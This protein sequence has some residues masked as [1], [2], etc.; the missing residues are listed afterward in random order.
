MPPSP[1]A[2][3]YTVDE[4]MSV[5][6]SRQLED[7]EMVAQGLATPL[8]VAGFLLAK[9][10]HAPNLRFASAIG[11]ALVDDWAPLELARIERK[12]GFAL[13]IAPNMGE[14]P[15]P[16]VEEVR[17]LREEIDPLGVRRLETLGGGARKGLIRAI[18]AAEEA[19]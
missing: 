19:L 11:Q 15:P 16:T 18:L 8:V 9:R 10:T 2:E 14:T 1:P 12:T 13:E 7:G 5:C 4:L 17:L 6:I 3:D